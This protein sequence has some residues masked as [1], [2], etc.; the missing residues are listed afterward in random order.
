MKYKG[1]IFDLDGTIGDTMGDVVPSMNSTLRKYGYPERSREEII[2]FI[3][4]GAMN[5]VRRSLPDYVDKTDEPLLKEFFRLY[6]D[7]YCSH[8]CEETSAYEGMSELFERLKGKGVKL[9]VLSNKQHS[10]TV[11]VTE[12]LYGSDMFE[13]IIGQGEFPIKPD[14]AA[15]L[16]I[17]KLFGLL[18]SDMALVGDSNVDMETG[19]NAGM[20]PIGVLW[21]YRDRNVIEEAGAA[22]IAADPKELGRLLGL[23]IDNKW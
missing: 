6:H 16:H 1:I 11:M 20:T 19:I 21:G 14:P 7:T 5:L 8:C 17:A 18:P 12:Y 22:A 2:S 23:S 13:V 10:Q 4:N 15:P 3:N 9:A